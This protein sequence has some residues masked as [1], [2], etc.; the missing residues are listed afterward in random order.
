MIKSRIVLMALMVLGVA[1]LPGL[2]DRPAGAADNAPNPAPAAPTLNGVD[3]TGLSGEQIAA[4]MKLLGETRC[5]C[6][7]SMT[8]S[9]CRVKDP[10][11]PRSLPIARS[12]IAD[13]K[14]GKDLATIKNNL[15]ATMARL[16]S[17]PPGATAPPPA[18]P[19]K[20]FKIDITG[21]PYRGPKGAP[22]TLVVFSD[23]Q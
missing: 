5:N 20:P 7:C 16:A 2:G 9:E 1:L 6:G 17:P 14:A 3:F 19:G 8:I 23:Y 12:V 18:D 22:V 11:C 4:A 13:F 15:N 10:N 21:A